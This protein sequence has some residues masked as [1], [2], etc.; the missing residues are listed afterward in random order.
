MGNVLLQNPEHPALGEHQVGTEHSEPVGETLV[1]WI[2]F[3]WPG[4]IKQ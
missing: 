2:C 4:D 1:S 3:A